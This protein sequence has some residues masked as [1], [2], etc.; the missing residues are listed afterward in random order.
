MV[1]TRLERLAIVLA[2]AIGILTYAYRD[3]RGAKAQIV[4]PP[5]NGMMMGPVTAPIGSCTGSEGLWTFSQDG[6][7]TFCSAGVW[8]TKI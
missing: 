2:V 6:H 8:V 3:Q 1:F 5:G 4:N 7:G